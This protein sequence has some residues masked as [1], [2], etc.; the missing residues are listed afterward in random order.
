MKKVVYLFL[1]IA[2]MGLL[3]CQ[4][5]STKL[6]ADLVNNP[7][8]ATSGPEGQ[9]AAIAFAQTE[10]DFGR[11]IMGE[12]V[13][14]VYK[15]TNT[16]DKDLIITKVSTSCGCTASQYT[17]DPVKPGE[18]GRIEVTFDSSGQKGMVN[19]SITVI[20]NTQPQNNTLRLRAQVVTPET[21]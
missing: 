16:G 11:L 4:H 18:D 1:L 12:K 2:G 7:K 10:H 19:K 3:A 9:I 14:F 8:S 5:N 6:P 21:N 13:S 15:F 17:T 20:S